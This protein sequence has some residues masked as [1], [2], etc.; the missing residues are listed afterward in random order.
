MKN[1]YFALALALALLVNPGLICADDSGGST[2]S[3][4]SGK[5]NILFIFADDLSFDSVGCYGNAEVSTP[6]IDRIA[7][8]GATFDRAYNMGGWNG[9]ICLA[10]RAMLNTGRSLW[11][12]QELDQVLREHRRNETKYEGRLWSQQ[13][14]DAGYSTFF[15]GKWHVSAQPVDVF[16]NVRNPRGGMPNQTPEGYDRPH[17]GQEDVWSPS[18]PKFEGFWKGGTHWSEVVFTDAD[19]FIANAK[20]SDDPFFMYIAFNAPHDPRQSP[21]E[22]VDMYPQENVIVPDNFMAR[23]PYQDE[24]GCGENL[25]DARLAPFPRTPYS[26]R[27]N[28]QE[29]YAIISHMD[30]QIGRI[31]D[32]LE[33]T[34]MDENTYVI[35]SADHGL[36]CGHHGLIGKQNMYEHS[37]RVPLIVSG[38]GIEAGQRLDAPVYLQDIM[39]T[40]LGIADAPVGDEVEFQD[41]LP[42]INA[43]VDSKYESIYGAYVDLQRMII[44]DNIKLIA[45]PKVP[46]LRMFDIEND[47]L[48]M[49]DLAT[50]PEFAGLRDELFNELADL[51]LEMG[52]KLDLRAAFEAVETR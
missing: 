2:E 44:R 49:N 21:Q 22:F 33:E 47:P 14:E 36:A 45:Y 19:T 8:S 10:S 35:F 30:E 4:T 52:D 43:E 5:P 25:R 39:P 50:N 12:A 7:A 13:M 17:E 1:Y 9:A 28:R 24:I 31:L 6:S 20:S 37:M 41:L 42:I 34:G 18:D 32:V 29:Y 26:V 16:N 48:E 51:Q 46:V 27:V 11:R 40:T 23:Y 3:P 15:T 38:P